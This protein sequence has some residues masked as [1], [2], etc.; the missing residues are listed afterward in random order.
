MPG[1]PSDFLAHGKGD[2]VAVAVRDLVRG[3]AVGGYL[4]STETVTVELL[5]AVPL[6]HKLALV[7]MS[8]GED[9][10]E[11][12]VRIG[13]ATTDIRR[14]DYVHVHNIGSARWHSSAA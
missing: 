14:G 9:V 7:D 3:P 4:A 12:G 1:Q 2:T 13:R 11:Y 6:G 8:D 10:I 5:A